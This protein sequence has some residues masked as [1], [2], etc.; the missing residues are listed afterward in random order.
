MILT[1]A[2]IAA[3]VGGEVHGPERAGDVTVGGASQDSREIEPGMLFV[4]IVADRDGHE[5]IAAAVVAGAAAYLTSGRIL[6]STVQGSG[7]DVVSAM[8]GSAL[9]PAVV[10]ADT[11]DALTALGRTARD[12]IDPSVPVVGITGSV[13]KTTTKD[14]LTAILNRE[15]RVHANRRSFNNELGVPL[16]LLA[17]PD[18]TEAVVIELGSRGIGHIAALCEV[19]RPTVGVVTTVGLA[20]TSELGSLA[21][22]VKAKGELIEALG[23]GHLAVLNAGVP[24]VAAMADLT[25]ARVVTFGAGGDLQAVDIELDDELTPRFRLVGSDVDVEIR[26]GAKGSHQVD[27]AVAASLV[28]LE[29]GLS[30]DSVVAGLA[31]PVLSPHRMELRRTASGARV[32]N[33]SYNANPLSTAAALRSLTH[34]PAERRTAVLGLMAELGDV[35]AAEHAAIGQLAAEL[36]VRLIAVATPEYGGE[37]AADIDEARAL[38]GDLDERDAVLIT[39]SRVAGLDVLVGMLVDV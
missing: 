39:G 19:A 17:T 1:V 29:L 9:P 12:R 18:D 15:R 8:R 33:D 14:F 7:Y 26:L 11:A 37:P 24:E 30:T 21:G 20:H 25:D 10:V 2:E 23:P 4:P 22:V 27:N 35:A 3:A 36:G 31:E 38:L 13:G 5:Y 34:L 32:V 16:T 6:D 28:A